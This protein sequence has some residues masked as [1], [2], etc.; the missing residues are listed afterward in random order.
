M[1]LD[2]LVEGTDECLKDQEDDDSK[3]PA[4]GFIA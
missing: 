4:V 1:F 3:S 2:A